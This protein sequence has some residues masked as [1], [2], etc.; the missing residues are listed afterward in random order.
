LYE[1]NKNKKKFT[2]KESRSGDSPSEIGSLRI[3][4]YYKPQPRRLRKESRKREPRVDLPYFHGKN[5][6]EIYLDW[7]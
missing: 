3:N 1:K 5:N 2:Y 7:K 4:D 6:V